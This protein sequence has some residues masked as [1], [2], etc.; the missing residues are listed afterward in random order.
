MRR[1]LLGLLKGA[2]NISTSIAAAQDSRPQIHRLVD[3]EGGTGMGGMERPAHPQSNPQ[4]VATVAAFQRGEIA[5]GHFA[6]AH[7][8]NFE[9]REY[10]RSMVSAYTNSDGRLTELARSLTIV[11]ERNV[12]SR[13]LAAQ[14]ATTQRQLAH[15]GADAF[16]RAYLDAEIAACTRMLE[17]LDRTLIPSAGRADLRSAL[18]LEIR[19]MVAA[20]LTRARNLRERI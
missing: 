19:P 14:A 20:N 11:P 18:Q 12:A 3:P 6:V 17:Q 10:G 5:L 1:Y 4:I 2:L 7:A 13:R 9:V 16:D 8:R 15:L